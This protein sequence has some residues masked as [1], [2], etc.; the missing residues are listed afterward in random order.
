MWHKGLLEARVD[1]V[2]VVEVE[3]SVSPSARLPPGVHRLESELVK[4][5]RGLR[6]EWQVA[7]VNRGVA[8]SKGGGDYSLAA[9]RSPRR[10]HAAGPRVSSTSS[11]GLTSPSTRCVTDTPP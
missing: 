9:T 5:C 3:Q 2:S 10:N 7:R 1:S 4:D 6:L 8:T 11:M